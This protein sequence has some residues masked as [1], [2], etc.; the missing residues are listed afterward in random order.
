MVNYFVYK[1][2]ILVSSKSARPAERRSDGSDPFDYAQ[3]KL[4]DVEKR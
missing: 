2:S 1:S 3:D 4:H